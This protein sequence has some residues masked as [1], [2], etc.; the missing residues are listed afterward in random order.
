MKVSIVIPVFN[1]EDYIEDA[2][3]SAL[4]QTY[5]DFEVIVVND[6]ST[7]RSAEIAR[8]FEPDVRVV[9]QKNKRQAAAR[10]T[11]IRVAN[12]EFILPLDADDLISGN[13]LKKTVPLM[14]DDR[15]AI[16]ATGMQ[17]FGE[18]HEYIHP[19]GVS[20]RI[21]KESNELP[22]C[23]LI[24]NKVLTEVGGYNESPLI[25]GME[26]WDLWLKILGSGYEVSIIDEPL[27][28]YR[29]HSG[30]TCSQVNSRREEI[31]KKVKEMHP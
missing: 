12:G 22:C 14:E 21:E 30:S 29:V 23:S 15:V 9:D 13:Y 8:S 18:R 28:F 11:G 16:V 4:G 26:D 25:H 3:K 19:V 5:S 20:W 6:G 24:R 1:Q 2:I 31:V 7:D 10:N 17:Y 27:F